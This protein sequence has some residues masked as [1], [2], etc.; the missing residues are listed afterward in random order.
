VFYL[1]Q[2]IVVLFHRVNKLIIE[3]CQNRQQFLFK[4]SEI[5]MTQQKSRYCIF[6]KLSSIEYFIRRKR[7]MHCSFYY[8]SADSYF[9]SKSMN[10][11][12]VLRECNKQNV[13]PVSIMRCSFC[14]LSIPEDSSP[15]PQSK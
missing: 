7:I 8:L 12:S 6:N 4:Y 11:L 2:Q 9:P 3:Q 10:A 13:L 14:V 1:Y 5:L 15:L